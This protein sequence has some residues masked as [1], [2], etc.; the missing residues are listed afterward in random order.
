MLWYIAVGSA[1]GGVIRY[2]LGGLI[3]RLAGGS[4]P[5][6][7][8]VI[9][10]SGSLLLG[11]LLRYALESSSISPEMRAMLTIGFCGGYT[12]FSTFSY[13]TIRLLEAGSYGRAGLYIVASVVLSLAG[14]MVGFGLARGA[15][16]V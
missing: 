5:L 4:F 15:M 7:T 13:D 14:T 11:F 9:N 1:V 16:K 8:L 12:T 3:Q 10:V 2:L 6:G